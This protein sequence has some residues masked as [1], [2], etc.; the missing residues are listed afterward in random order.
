MYICMY[1]YMYVCIYVYM[2]ICMYTCFFYTPSGNP[3]W[4]LDIPELAM[5]PFRESHGGSAIPV[6]PVLRVWRH[7]DGEHFGV[8]VMDS[9]GTL[10]SDRFFTVVR[11]YDGL[12]SMIGCFLAISPSTCAFEPKLRL[13]PCHVLVFPD[14]YKCIGVAMLIGCHWFHLKEFHVLDIF[15]TFICLILWTL[16]RS[17]S[18]LFQVW[19]H[20]PSY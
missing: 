2:Y 9:I 13:N 20:F 14:W 17:T 15:W 16:Y 18:W 8:N 1:V 12:I 6:L 5:E 3:T 10:L 7:F 11:I 4:Q 19:V